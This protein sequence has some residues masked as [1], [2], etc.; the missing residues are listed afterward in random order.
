MIPYIIAGAIGYG[1][2]KLLEEDTKKYAGGGMTNEDIL[3]S[4]LTSERQTQTN[5]LA[6]FY[7]TLG[8]VMLLRNYGTLIA[9]RNGRRVEITNVKYSKTTSAITNRLKALAEQMGYNVSYVS[10][11][12]EG[13][14]TDDDDDSGEIQEQ[15]DEL[16]QD[17]SSDE[18]KAFCYEH[19]IDEEDGQ[20]MSDFIY[21]QTN[22]RCKEIIQ[23]IEDGYYAGG[24]DDDDNDDDEYAEGGKTGEKSTKKKTIKKLTKNREPKMVRQYFDDSPYSYAGGG[25]IK[26]IKKKAEKLLEDSINYRFKNTD[27]GSGWLFQLESPL[28]KNVFNL[29]EEQ[30]YLD[31]FSPY[32][33]GIEDYDDLSKEEQDYYYEDWKEELFQSTFE[34]FKEKC[35]KHLDDFIEYIQQAKEYQ[36]EMNEYAEGGEAGI[37]HLISDNATPKREINI[38]EDDILRESKKFFNWKNVSVKRI[39]SLGSTD[40]DKFIEFLYKKGYGKDKYAKGGGIKNY[41]KRELELFDGIFETY[42]NEKIDEKKILRFRNKLVTMNIGKDNSAL[43]FVINVID[44]ILDGELVPA[45]VQ[46][47]YEMTP[48]EIKAEEMREELIKINPSY[49]KGKYANVLMVGKD[50][51]LNFAIKLM[52]SITDGEWVE[53]KNKLASGG[54]VSKGYMVFNYTDDIYATDEVFKT[55]KIAN[56]FIKEFRSRFSKQ[57]YYRDNQMNKIDV[58]DID[59]LAIPSD[60]NPLN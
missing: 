27:M 53:N 34:A 20:E 57:G 45:K 21:S 48:F 46:A 39:K 51:T 5:N 33:M 52:F 9:K 10:E 3:R 49:G 38:I 1:I 16:V 14:S 12:S 59:L 40:Y 29:L 42:F 24:Y 31:E 30:L 41:T 6:T 54:S 19:D 15:L 60:F 47:P 11:F 32:D 7:S 43:D 13:G 22:N 4:F 55:Q 37:I 44:S 2:A 17:F 36:D 23:E 26:G 58:E 25:A 18:Y 50:V 28:N 56:D 35:K 8:S